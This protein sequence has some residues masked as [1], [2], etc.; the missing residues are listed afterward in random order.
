[1]STWV[2]IV[3]AIIGGGGPVVALITRLGRRNDRQH[4]E[5]ARTLDRIEVKMD[6]LDDRLHDHL[7]DHSREGS[8][9]AREI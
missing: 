8:V 7:R 2:P 1:M 5:T 9:S 3:V 4:G 6:R